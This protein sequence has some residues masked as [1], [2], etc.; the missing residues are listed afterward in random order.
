[1]SHQLMPKDELTEKLRNLIVNQVPNAKETNNAEAFLSTL[2]FQSIICPERHVWIDT[3]LDGIGVDLEDWS[4]EGEW[5]NAVARVKL[6]SLDAAKELVQTWLS[7][8]NLDNYTNVNKEYQP[9]FK[10]HTSSDI[11]N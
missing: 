10:Q 2:S 7:C 11:G 6:D 5:D 1:M 8:G 4:V 3:D 9:I